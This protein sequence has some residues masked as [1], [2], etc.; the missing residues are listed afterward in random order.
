M[1]PIDPR[2]FIMPVSW[3]SNY[4]SSPW[5]RLRTVAGR[6]GRHYGMDIAPLLNPT[7]QSV[8]S[9]HAGTVVYRGVN[10]NFGNAVVVYHGVN[11]RGKHVYTLYGHLASF[12]SAYTLGNAVT[13]GQQLGIMGTTGRSTGIHLHYEVLE[14]DNLLRLPASGTGALGFLTRTYSVNPYD[15]VPGVTT[16]RPYLEGH[17]FYS[18]NSSGGGIG[19]PVYT[20]PIPTAQ[21]VLEVAAYL[22]GNAPEWASAMVDIIGSSLSAYLFKGNLFAQ[23]A[24]SAI[25][26]SVGQN[27]VQAISQGG[28][29]ADVAAMLTDGSVVTLKRN[30]L[31]DFGQDFLGAFQNAAVGTFSSFLAM[32]LGNAIGLQGFGGELVTTGTATVFGQVLNNAVALAQGGT[33]AA[34]IG[35]NLFHGLSGSG[36]FGT[37]VDPANLSIWNPGMLSGAVGSFFG[38]KLGS[39]ILSPTN[40]Q[41]AVLSSIGSAAGAWAF[42]AGAGAAGSIGSIGASIATAFGSLGNIV[43]P[44]VG[45]LVGFLVGSLIGRLFG[46]MKPRI[47]TAAAETFLDLS[48]GRWELGAIS[49]ANNGNRQLVQSMAE[50]ARDSINGIVTGMIDG[51]DLA[52]ITNSISLTHK[53]GHTG[54]TLWMDEKVGASWVRRYSGSDASAAVDAGGLI[55][56]RSTKIAGGDIILKRALYGSQAT[57]LTGVYGDLLTAADYRRYLENRQTI[58][59]LMT[60][61]PV[62]QFTAGWFASLARAAELGLA[63]FQA[64]DFFG[65]LKGFAGSFG[66]GP[67]LPE[68]DVQRHFETLTVTAEGTSIRLTASDGSAPFGLLSASNTVTDPAQAAQSVYIA[69]FGANVGYAWWTGVSSAGNDIGVATGAAAGVTFDDQ[70]RGGDDIFIGSAHS[71]YLSSWGGYDWLDGGAGNDRLLGGEGDDVLIGGDGVDELQGSSGNDYLSGGDGNDYMQGWIGGPAPGGLHGGPGNDVMVGGAG[72]DTLFGDDGDDILIVDQ[73]GG[74]TFDYYWGIAGSDTAS[75]ERFT[76][77]ISF[78]LIAGRGDGYTAR[79]YG[80]GFISI[81]NV[82]GSG[83]ADTVWGDEVANVLRGLAG[84]DSLH[85]MDGNDTLEGGAGADLLYGWS[86]YDTASYAN[87]GGAVYANLATGAAASGDAGGDVFSSIENL[88]GSAF[89][90]ELHGNA[91]NN[92]LAGL[93]GDDL[94]GWSA[95]LDTVNGGAGY[96]KFDAGLATQAVTL[97]G[98]YLSAGAASASLTAVESFAGT[99]WADSLTGTSIDET[100]EG[101]AGSDYINGQNGSDVYLFGRGD[102]YDTVAETTD[103]ANAIAL[104][105]GIDWRNVAIAGAGGSG[106]LAV[107]IRD[108]GET[109]SVGTNFS[110][111]SNGDHNHK[112]KT[113]DLGGV[114]AVDIGLVDWTPAGAANEA[115]TIVYGAQAK[116]DLIFSYG[117]V[118]T[119]YAA[120]NVNNWENRGNVV[121]AGDAPDS[122]VTSSGDDTFIFE[123]GNGLD[124]LRDSGGIDTIVMGPS[125]AANDVIYEAKVRF[126]DDGLGGQIADLWVGLRDPNNPNASASQV[127]DSIQIWEGATIF[128]DLDTSQT[129]LNTVEHLRV[130][131]QEID[132]T[133]AGINWVWTYYHSYGGGG[134]GG[135]I[136]P[137]AIDLDG[138]GIELRS[139]EGSRISTV[140]AGGNLWRLGWLG[141]DDGFL[142]LDRDGNG[143]IDRLGEI[144]F[145]DDLKGAKSDLEGLAAYDTNRDG[146]LDGQDARWAEFKVWRDKNQ[147]GIGLGKELVSLGDAGIVSIGLKGR[148]TGFTPAD[149]IDNTVLATT[150]IEWADPERVGLGYDVA[151]AVHQVRSDLGGR[152]LAEKAKGAAG[153]D[154]IEARLYGIQTMTAAEAEAAKAR[155]GKKPGAGDGLLGRVETFLAGAGRDSS[156]LLKVADARGVHSANVADAAA[157]DRGAAAD[158]FARSAWSGDA[159]KSG[160]HGADLA[161]PPAAEAAAAPVPTAA[162]AEGLARAITFFEQQ[163]AAVAAEEALRAMRDAAERE[164]AALPAA[165]PS[166]TEAARLAQ[167]DPFRLLPAGAAAIDPA[168]EAAGDEDRLA[169]AN[170][171]LVQALGAFGGRGA[172]MM[173]DHGGMAGGEDGSR[174][175][176]AVSRRA[177]VQS[178]AHVV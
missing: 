94:F 66:Y 76:A 175:A 171:R 136:P 89:D 29:K 101:R 107:S 159:G 154:D 177:F 82:T 65:G 134:G 112:I 133:K 17:E 158:K 119:I 20:D 127:A 11:E 43:A 80:D 144:Q 118:D 150:A 52:Y 53:Y 103:A 24:G 131:G 39:L 169:L 98:T 115:G 72:L 143:A 38:A 74:A 139:V 97:S 51:D 28:V 123:R 64:S 48:S 2:D 25:I 113:L 84:I 105:S 149:G 56:L 34:N 162:E 108:T 79:S 77:G 30:V 111:G 125:V 161:T 92:S 116:A 23:V 174:S 44:F 47:P 15:P 160:S 70:N 7:N 67:D 126:N 121:Y 41:G 166:A 78:D 167:Q 114:S 130:G 14:A 60:Q 173:M 40:T 6:P 35:S 124:F 31:D 49:S 178:H 117:G 87:S 137:L 5:G 140:D 106:S 45:S 157:A 96:D 128:M 21:D 13:Q 57:T 63:K 141:P 147:D 120:G 69:S 135:I 99:Q 55:G 129:K 4:L 68:F 146:K 27:V 58:N 75:F 37:T 62:T 12:N 73:D 104:K 81:E 19:G 145:I 156:G 122:I 110:Y 88:T 93:A 109:I 16:D 95:G 168:A 153:A 165:P 59:D 170:L 46:R 85:G 8:V 50:I 164:Q 42:G 9:V 172:P 54:S 132:L 83:H 10:S 22:Q 163:R 151:L 36:L 71:D 91:G 86:G 33:A 138:D 3:G 61:Q 176:W 102:G 18:T 100:F 155:A 1:V 32:E 148:A 26:Q 152:T 90:D 142:A